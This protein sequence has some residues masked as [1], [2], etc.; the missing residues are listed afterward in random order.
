VVIKVISNHCALIAPIFG[1]AKS[2]SSY[3]IIVYIEVKNDT[4]DALRILSIFILS[5]MFL[6]ILG[7]LTMLRC[8][9]RLVR[10]GVNLRSSHWLMRRVEVMSP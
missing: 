1:S 9:F 5:I 2:L 6:P 7:S 4:F 8:P 10:G 3:Q